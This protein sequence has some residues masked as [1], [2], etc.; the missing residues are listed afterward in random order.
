[1]KWIGKAF[2][3]SCAFLSC[4]LFSAVHADAAPQDSVKI[5][6]NDKLVDF[7]EA[8]PVVDASSQLQ[9]PFRP[10]MENLGYQVDWAMD[11]KE[12]KVSMKKGD[13]TLSLKTGDSF[14]VLDGKKVNTSSMIGMA[15]GSVYIPLRFVSETLGNLVQWDQDNQLAIVGDDGKYHAP[16]WYKPKTNAMLDFAKGY[17]GT[18]YVWGGETPGGFD[19]SG[20]VRFVFAQTRGIDL[21]RTSTEIFYTVGTAVAVPQPGDLVYFD[22]SGPAHIGIYLGNGQFISAT[23]SHGVRIDSIYSSYWSSRYIGAKSI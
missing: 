18:R 4:A 10:L 13:K 1:M 21:P 8:K 19:C 2:V 20:F 15:Q 11:G 22:K 14:V 7:P 23:S 3:F 5:Q 6:V 17:L 12:V 16:A 9:V